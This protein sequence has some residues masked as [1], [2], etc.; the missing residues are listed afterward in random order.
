MRVEDW[1][2]EYLSE[3]YLLGYLYEKGAVESAQDYLS[4]REQWI[5]RAG[6]VGAY[7]YNITYELYMNWAEGVR[8][9]YFPGARLLG[10]GFVRLKSGEMELN[11][12]SLGESLPLSLTPRGKVLASLVFGDP[13]RYEDAI[14]L[15]RHVGHLLAYFVEQAGLADIHLFAGV[16]GLT[17]FQTLS[18]FQSLARKGYLTGGFEDLENRKFPEIMVEGETRA[19]AIL[20]EFGQSHGDVPPQE[21]RPMQPDDRKEQRIGQLEKVLRIEYDKLNAF[22]QEIAINSSEPAKFELRQRLKRDVLPDIHKHELEYAQL[23]AER[24]NPANIPAE[25]AEHSLNEVIQAVRQ[26]ETL[27]EAASIKQLQ[28]LLI[29]IR[30]KLDEPGKTAA[31]KLKVALPI[32]PLIASYEMEMDTEAVLLRAWRGL[33]SLF[34]GK[35]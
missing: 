14:L 16:L 33:K 29:D 17:I 4:L 26:I 23:L 12:W 22:E 13:P 20:A 15:V 28:S 10:L 27:P 9:W 3:N 30:K 5:E 2:F 18:F 34:G 11:S 1:S 7:S 24:A 8:G 19:K 6:W 31:A 35:A 32:I 21:V 25:Q